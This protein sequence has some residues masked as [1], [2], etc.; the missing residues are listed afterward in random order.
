MAG[1]ANG[2]QIVPGKPEESEL[3][4]LVVSTEQR[5]MPP[6]DKGEAVPPQKAEVI[7]RLARQYNVLVSIGDHEEE[8]EASLAAAVPFVRVTCDTIEEAWQEVARTLAA[9]VDLSP[10]G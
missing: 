9:V 4:G 8:E 1:G 5:R 10:E 3:H 7:A 2:E 6:R